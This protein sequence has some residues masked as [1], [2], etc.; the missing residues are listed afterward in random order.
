MEEKYELKQVRVR[1][2]LSEAESLYSTEEFRD[3]ES[4]AN[5]M[6]EV[7]SQLDRE[8]C[9][10]VN[11]DSGLRPINFNI[12]SMGSINQALVPIQNVF[13]SAILSNAAAIMLLHNHPSGRVE[14]SREDILI[15]QKIIEAAKWVDI[16][17]VDHIIVGGGNGNQYSFRNKKGEEYAFSETSVSY[18]KQ[19]DSVTE[20]D[21]EL[22]KEGGLVRGYDVNI[23][24]TLEKVVT[25]SAVSR[26]EAEEIVE[27]AYYNSQY[28]LDDENVTGVSFET[29]QEHET[30]V[31]HDEKI[32]A[33]LIK[34]GEVPER[35]VIKD[36]LRDLQKMVGGGIEVVYPFQERV[37]AIVNDEGKL[38]G[39]P[40][41]RA[42]A[43]EKGKIYDILA[44]NVLIVGV[45]GPDFCSLTP[46]Q[47]DHYEKRF[48]HPEI[49]IQMGRGIKAIPL[50]VA[51]GSEEKKT[52]KHKLEEQFI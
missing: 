50:S 36:E 22:I 3:A 49:F 18:L 47:M 16:P 23:K 42:L 46:E 43:D 29:L 1:L 27:K 32:S 35:V 12:V 45:S 40:L 26:E 5:A 4:A 31:E 10:V 48:Y 17:V 9:C 13:K 15:T 25:V 24:E 30:V 44:G 39:L 7:M 21:K 51:S 33:L 8:Y 52:N 11:L 6:A 37:A 34:P 19:N 28:V 14:P 20:V 38:L 2:A 41:N